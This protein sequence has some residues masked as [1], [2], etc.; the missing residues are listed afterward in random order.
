MGAL[1]AFELAHRLAQEDLRSPSALI[2]S[3][4]QPPH[5]MTRSVPMHRLPGPEFVAALREMKGTPDEVLEHAELMELLL[6]TLR[7]DFELCEMYS[8]RD[9][10][11]LTCDVI[12]FG[13]TEDPN[14][15]AQDLDAW[16]ELTTGAFASR[17]F[18]GDH[19]FLET[20]GEAMLKHI[21]G[22][23]T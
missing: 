5:R 6:P 8:F 22:L 21:A 12:A 2:V 3:A 20:H 1:I 15:T 23:H 4:A 18:A 9:R 13:G 14:V 11:P 19:F 17:R 16:R 10:P 7:A